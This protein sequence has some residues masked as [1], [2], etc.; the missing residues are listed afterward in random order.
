MSEDEDSPLADCD[1]QCEVARIAVHDTNKIRLF[2]CIQIID[3]V[4]IDVCGV[5]V[6]I[7]VVLCRVVP[8]TGEV[9]RKVTSRFGV[10]QLKAADN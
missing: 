9:G 2:V 6:N 1:G 4:E 7:Y 5:D 8:R 3:G 10:G